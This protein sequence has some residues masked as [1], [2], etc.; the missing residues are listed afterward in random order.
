MPKNL[1]PYMRCIAFLS[2]KIIKS[3][4]LVVGIPTQIEGFWRPAFF[5]HEGSRKAL[6]ECFWTLYH[7][8]YFILIDYPSIENKWSHLNL[9]QGSENK[10]KD[11]KHKNNYT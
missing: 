2:L 11:N 7:N 9:K 4:K 6:N 3:L 1:G 10:G 8:V 5:N